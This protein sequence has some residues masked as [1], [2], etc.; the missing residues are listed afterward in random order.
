[1]SVGGVPSVIAL[2]MLAGT[3][4]DHY[5]ASSTAGGP[6]RAKGGPGRRARFESAVAQ[7]FEGIEGGGSSVTWP[8]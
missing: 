2:V 4:M 3:C 8:R 6:E 7:L 1:M 5:P